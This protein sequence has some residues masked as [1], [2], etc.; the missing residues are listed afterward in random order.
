M[1]TPILA[2]DCYHGSL[3]PPTVRKM[4]VIFIKK[5]NTVMV[6]VEKENS[7]TVMT[8]VA[9]EVAVKYYFSV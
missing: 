7:M 3:F 5:R 8:V 6:L 1:S 9:V 4:Y 2:Y